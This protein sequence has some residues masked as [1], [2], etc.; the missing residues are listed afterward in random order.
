MGQERGGKDRGRN[1]ILEG[2]GLVFPNELIYFFLRGRLN[3][4]NSLNG[5]YIE[6]FLYIGLGEEKELQEKEKGR[7]I[8]KGG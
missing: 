1:F 5:Q 4:G 7:G 8:R 6:A 2:S 3:E